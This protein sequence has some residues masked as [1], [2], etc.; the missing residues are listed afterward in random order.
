[1]VLGSFSR[2]AAEVTIFLDCECSEADEVPIC[3]GRAQM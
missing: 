3:G 1:M 2:T